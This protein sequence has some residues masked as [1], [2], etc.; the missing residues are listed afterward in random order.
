MYWTE[1]EIFT[2]VDLYAA[3]GR[4]QEAR[5]TIKQLEADFRNH[6]VCP[7]EIGTIHLWLGEKNEAFRWYEK[8]Y[9]ERSICMSLMKH[10]PRLHPV[11]SNPRDES[12][13]RRVGLP[14]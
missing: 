12:L 11:R 4:T 14:Q 2:R 3:A 9:D 7:Y 6:F 8:A 10:D 5:K 13:I 1:K